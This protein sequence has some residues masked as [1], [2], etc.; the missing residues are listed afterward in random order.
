MFGMGMTEV[1]VI[2]AVALIFIGPKKLPELA[3]SL[4]RAMNE[5]KKAASEIKESMDVDNDL[6]SLKKT[7][8]DVNTAIKNPID[9][10][11]NLPGNEDDDDDAQTDKSKDKA[12]ISLKDKAEISLKDKAGKSDAEDED[13]YDDDPY[14]ILPINSDDAEKSVDSNA[15]GNESDKKNEVSDLITEQQIS[16]KIDKPEKIEVKQA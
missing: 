3:R 15:G 6:D 10:I 12:E 14:G 11:G 5:F 8:D 2:L 9:L 4:G 16:E 1:L 13:N 7:Y